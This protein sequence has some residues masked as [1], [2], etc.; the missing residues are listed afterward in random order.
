MHCLRWLNTQTG[1]EYMLLNGND[2]AAA[3]RSTHIGSGA[4]TTSSTATTS[5]KW[6]LLTTTTQTTTITARGDNL[7]TLYAQDFNSNNNTFDNGDYNY[8]RWKGRG[9]V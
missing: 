6:I 8:G 3:C 1:L 4:D 5:T 2:C 9:Q 7:G